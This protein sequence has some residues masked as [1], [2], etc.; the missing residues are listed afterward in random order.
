MEREVTKK[1][2]T[3]L[4][5]MSIRLY[6]TESKAQATRK[7]QAV[8]KA[9]NKGVLDFDKLNKIVE[10]HHCKCPEMRTDRIKG[11]VMTHTQLIR[12][13]LEYPVAYEEYVAG[14]NAEYV[15][16][17]INDIKTK[18]PEPPRFPCVYYDASGPFYFHELTLEWHTLGSVN[19]R[20]DAYAYTGASLYILQFIDDLFSVGIHLPWQGVKTLVNSY[21]AGVDT[22]A[23][24]SP[25]YEFSCVHNG[26]NYD[27]M[28][29]GVQIMSIDY[30]TMRSIISTVSKGHQTPLE[31]ITKHTQHLLMNTD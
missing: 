7:L 18:Y 30:D 15:I 27:F 25:G 3:N 22:P 12:F 5:D 23:T 8:R 2:L 11:I 13:C 17:M 16:E 26:D 20:A 31:F 21:K 10:T 29:S 9:I 14:G 28:I 19:G 4:I 6:G 1:D 24:L